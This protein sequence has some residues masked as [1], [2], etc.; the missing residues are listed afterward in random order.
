M[1]HW[2]VLPESTSQASRSVSNLKPT[3]QAEVQ[4]QANFFPER[5]GCM[6]VHC[7]S[8]VLG[9]AAYQELSL[10]PVKPRNVSPPDHQGQAIKGHPL[11]SNLKNSGTRCL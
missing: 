8:S 11:G 4:G 1:E 6:P 3:L 10:G 7:L 9:V 5:L 2:P